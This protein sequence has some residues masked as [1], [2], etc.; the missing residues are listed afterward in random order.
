VVGYA[1]CTWG[2]VGPDMRQAA[3]GHPATAAFAWNPNQTL[4]EAPADPFQF[5]LDTMKWRE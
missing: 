5:L 3:Q 1:G 4:A 2:H